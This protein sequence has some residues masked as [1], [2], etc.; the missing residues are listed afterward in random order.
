M[1]TED[2][3]IKRKKSKMFFIKGISIF[4]FFILF[5]SLLGWK[6]FLFSWISFSRSQIFLSTLWTKADFKF[7]FIY[8]PFKFFSSRFFRNSKTMLFLFI[9]NIIVL[10]NLCI[11]LNKLFFLKKVMLQN[12]M[13]QFSLQI[14]KKNVFLWNG[15][16]LPIFL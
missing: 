16:F 13:F 12:F 3:S 2:S 4:K 9:L 5:L 14:A 1:K 8:D 11:Q 10:Q 15:F 7:F 6:F